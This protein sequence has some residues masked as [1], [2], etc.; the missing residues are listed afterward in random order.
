MTMLLLV[1][2]LSNSHE[3]FNTSPCGLMVSIGIS[4]T[5]NK[6]TSRAG[7][8]QTINVFKYESN[9][10]GHFI[11]TSI[12]GM[13]SADESTISTK[14]EISPLLICAPKKNVIIFINEFDNEN[15]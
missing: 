2:L 3:I 8:F 1:R 14:Y 11:R 9:F 4:S 5:A 7:T 15:I 12:A 10:S 6:R 13:I